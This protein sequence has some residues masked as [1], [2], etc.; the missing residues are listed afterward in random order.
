MRRNSTSPRRDWQQKVES[1]GL[2]YHTVNDKP[3]W[4]ESAYYE[5]TSA[6]VDRIEAATWKLQDMCLAAGQFIIDNNRFA[7]LKIPA[8]A[9]DAITKTWN[10][11]P[12]ALYGRFDLAYDGTQLKLLEYNADTP[13]ALVE[14]AVAQWYWLQDT[15]PKA[16]QFNSIHEKLVAKWKD[17]VAYVHQ[18]VY[19][20]H[21]D[22]DEDA[23]TVTYLRDTAQQAGIKTAQIVITDV[24]W[25][26]YK[27]RFEDLDE[28]EMQTIFKLYPW[29][30]MLKEDFGPH[31]LATMHKVQ[32][33]EPIWKMLFSNKGLLA[34]LWEMY[35]NHE[36][37][38]EAH[39]DGP[40]DMKNYVRK[41]LLSREGANIAVVRDGQTE[42]TYGEYG[43]EGFVYQALAPI[44]NIG[45]NY[46]VLGSWII[47][48]QG[49]AGMGIR[50]SDTI[51]TTNLSR[52]VPHFFK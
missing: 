22:T 11:E 10:E 24:G 19:F 12:P 15:F 41:P 46:P 3:Y 13:T 39:L 50:E 28:K 30:M 42:Y 48:D 14:A 34:I 4:N 29:E 23:M 17:L 32:W 27:F 21:V 18:P 6:E 36:L 45:G 2:T 25:N 7:D 1:V 37:L 35:P 5:F 43:A 8:E 16:D 49:P 44:P 26:D 9:I 47:A 51:V 52:F 40:G 20:T 31:A 33:I 38:L